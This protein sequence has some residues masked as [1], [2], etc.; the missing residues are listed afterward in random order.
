MPVLRHGLHRAPGAAGTGDFLMAW[1]SVPDL[2]VRASRQTYTHLAR[3]ERGGRV[4]FASGDFHRD[5]EFDADGYVIDYPTLARR[6]AT[7]PG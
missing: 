5:L 4:H 7:R 6:L 1:V 2:A 3:T